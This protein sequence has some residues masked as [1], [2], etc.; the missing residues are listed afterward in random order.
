VKSP[1]FWSLEQARQRANNAVNLSMAYAYYK[2]PEKELFWKSSRAHKEPHADNRSSRNYPS[3]SWRD[4]GKVFRQQPE[5]Y[6][7]ILSGIFN[8]PDWPNSV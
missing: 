8:R 4:T 7:A 3:L 1:A 5:E 6:T 2:K